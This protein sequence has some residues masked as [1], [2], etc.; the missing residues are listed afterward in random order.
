MELARKLTDLNLS[1]FGRSVVT[2]CAAASD[3]WGWH[4]PPQSD[5]KVRDSGAHLPWVVGH[6]LAIFWLDER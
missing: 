5:A 3:L 2:R 4:L 6:I 1:S